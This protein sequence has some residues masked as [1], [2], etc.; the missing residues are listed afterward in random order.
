LFG[1]TLAEP[2]SDSG[3]DAFA[4]CRHPVTKGLHVGFVLVCL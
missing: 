3:H 1:Q 2:H 4:A